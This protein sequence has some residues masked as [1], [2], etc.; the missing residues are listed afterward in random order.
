MSQR[1]E[2]ML[3]QNLLDERYPKGLSLRDGIYVTVRPLVREDRSRLLTFF[4]QIPEE[5]R[6]FLKD[7]VTDPAVIQAWCERIN[8]D[9][10]LPLLADVDGQIVGDI[11]LHQQPRGWM[12]HV[13]KVRVVI[14]PQ[15]RGRGLASR[16][17]QE[18]IQVATDC[19]LDKLDAEFMAPQ[20]SAMAPFETLGF[21]K[22][23]IL[24]QH[25]RDLKGRAHDFVLMVYD[26]RPPEESLAA[27]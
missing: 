10:V 12:S 7:D 4:R 25:V 16:L 17:I 27:Q 15:Y 20:L 14:H 18:I 8:Y 24:P 21:F 2:A 9:E 3:L 1:G 6:L 13:G 19:G 5:D 26:L 23:A 22:A 11:T